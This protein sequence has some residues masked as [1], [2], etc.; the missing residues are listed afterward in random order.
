MSFGPQGFYRGSLEDAEVLVI[1]DQHS[2]DDMFSGRAL[3]G[4]IGQRFQSYL[5]KSKKEYA[6]IRTLPVDTLDLS[7]GQQ[8]AISMDKDVTKG[9]DALVDAIVDA[10]KISQIIGVGPIASK[11]AK[12]LAKDYDVSYKGFT[13]ESVKK[14]SLNIIPRFDLPVHTRYWMG[15]SGDRAARGYRG[16]SSKKVYSGDYYKLYAPRWAT[17]WKAGS[18]SAEESKSY[19]TFK[20]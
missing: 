4:E 13:T 7:S 8:E 11:I 5:D 14:M 12:Q 18:M 3:T 20:N 17:K 1:A 6:I 15:T 16:S 2:H 19:E 9:R 10:G